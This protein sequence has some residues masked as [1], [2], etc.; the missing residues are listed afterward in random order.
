MF[1]T[2]AGTH[3]N[4]LAKAADLRLIVSSVLLAS[5][6]PCVPRGLRPEDTG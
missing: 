4:S 2:V 6:L 3:R 1:R 5:A